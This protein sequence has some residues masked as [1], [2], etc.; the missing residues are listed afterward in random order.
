M[1][2]AVIITLV[3]VLAHEL[4]VLLGLGALGFALRCA[5]LGTAFALCA[6]VVALTYVTVRRQNSLVRRVLRGLRKRSAQICNWAIRVRRVVANTN[7]ALVYTCLQLGRLLLRVLQLAFASTVYGLLIWG[8]FKTLYRIEPIGMLDLSLRECLGVGVGV[9][10][11][12]EALT[13]R[14]DELIEYLVDITVVPCG[15]YVHSLKT[16]WLRQRAR[17]RASR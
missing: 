14:A 12:G 7:T 5:V 15:E 9:L 2:L 10:L 13:D 17:V 8:F 3:L 16:E 1:R 4:E 11:F 6:A